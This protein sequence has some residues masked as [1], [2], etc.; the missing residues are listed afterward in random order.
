MINSCE[1][2]TLSVFLDPNA[3]LNRKPRGLVP[4]V[5]HVLEAS[6]H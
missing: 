2:L 3:M 4:L 1:T 6:E 5:G